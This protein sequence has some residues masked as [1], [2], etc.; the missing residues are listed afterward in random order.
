M[1]IWNEDEQQSTINMCS[2]HRFSYELTPQA[3]PRHSWVTSEEY[4][5]MINHG[6]VTDDAVASVFRSIFSL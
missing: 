4:R 1:K 2:Q 5:C 3:Q 6:S